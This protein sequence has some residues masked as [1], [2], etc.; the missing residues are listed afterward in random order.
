MFGVGVD[1]CF[2]VWKTEGPAFCRSEDLDETANDGL[3]TEVRVTEALGVEDMEVSVSYIS[4][5]RC[6]MDARGLLTREA[7]R[8]P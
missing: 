6:A 4:E 8:L 7:R 1:L 2:G 3:G 5:R